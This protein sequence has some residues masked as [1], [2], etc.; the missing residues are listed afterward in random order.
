MKILLDEC[1]PRKLKFELSGHEAYTVPQMG[2]ASKKN[3]ELLALM[4]EQFDVF[5]TVDSNMQ[6]QQNLDNAK[7]CI[8][9]AGSP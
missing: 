9:G 2:W 6:H 1:L 8:C 5:L 3:G 4:S 7:N